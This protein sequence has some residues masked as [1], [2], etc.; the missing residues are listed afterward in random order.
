MC[1]IC[2]DVNYE[3]RKDLK[4]VGI[5]AGNN[6]SKTISTADMLC[7]KN[8]PEGSYHIDKDFQAKFEIMIEKAVLEGKET[9]LVCDLNV[10]YLEEAHQKDIKEIF[11]IKS[12]KQMIKQLTKTTCHSKA[13]I[14]IF[15]SNNTTTISD[16]IVEQSSIS[17][18]DI[19]GINKKIHDQKYKP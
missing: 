11:R 4:T 19:V 10:N 18:H 16:T 6:S 13:L 12:L 15:C 3:R 2:N 7:I 1:Y 5:E 17:D 9:L 8:H 14:D